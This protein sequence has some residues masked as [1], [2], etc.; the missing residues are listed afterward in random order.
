MGRWDLRSEKSAHGGP[1]S[2]LRPHNELKTK[3]KSREG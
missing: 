3:E 1:L 2:Q